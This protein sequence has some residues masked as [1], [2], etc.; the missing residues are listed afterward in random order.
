MRKSL[1]LAAVLT[2]ALAG[3]A[4]A[5]TIFE[6]PTACKVTAE[7]LINVSAFI[8]TPL[9]VDS[10]F[11]SLSLNASHNITSASS[12]TVS[13]L[14]DDFA[15]VFRQG[16]GDS[17]C[18]ADISASVG[19]QTGYFITGDNFEIRADINTL[20][21][22]GTIINRSSPPFGTGGPITAATN[23]EVPQVNQLI[24]NVPFDVVGAPAY[25]TQPQYDLFRQDS[26]PTT[27]SMVGVYQIFPDRNANCKVDSGESSIMFGRG[28]VGP[29]GT[30]S[31]PFNQVK[32]N[33]G[34][35]ILQLVYFTD[36]D[37]AAF[38]SDCNTSVSNFGNV[39][40]GSSLVL[41]LQ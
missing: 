7:G 20:A 6:Y 8:A 39:A 27:G 10:D 11:G 34:R 15:E 2:A 25:L 19:A 4:G 1:T 40:D 14:K 29:D 37:L 41:E 38:S 28:T 17:G 13:D 21:S 24:V 16:Y 12:L 18:T 5:K 31:E 36:I 3:A 22:Q 32:V 33:P 30:Y 9:L 26:G 35:Y 23:W